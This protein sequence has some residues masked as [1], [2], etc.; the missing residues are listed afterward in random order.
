[1]LTTISAPAKFLLNP[2]L[3]LNRSGANYVAAVGDSGTVSID[4]IGLLNALRLSWLF[5]LWSI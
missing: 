3:D 4:Q 1:V 5:R 2:A